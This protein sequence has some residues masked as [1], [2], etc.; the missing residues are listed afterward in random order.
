MKIICTFV[1]LQKSKFRMKLPEKL[2]Q[3]DKIAIISSA[4]KVVMEEIQF[5]IETVTSWG[6]EVVLGKN[7]FAQQ[8]Q[9]AG[10]DEQRA[11]DLQTMLDDKSV[12]A[13]LFARGGYGTVRV[14]DKI[15]FFEFKKNPKWICGFSDITIL[16]SHIHSHF[17]I[18][19]L[20]S[21]M[22][23][24]FSK[25]PTEVLEKIKFVLLNSTS[26]VYETE[27]HLLNKS[28][29][30]KGILVGGN[31]SML[32]SALGS[33]S[34]VDTEGKILFLEDLDE[35]LY[36]IDRMMMSLK[37]AG[38][39]KNLAGLVIGGMNDMKD[40]TI[41]FGKNAEEIILDA[42]KEYDFPV[43]FNFSSG[44]ISNNF[45]LIFGREIELSV[46]KKTML[47]FNNGTA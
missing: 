10:S 39:L 15:N 14:I 4:R 19:T 26:L 33:E 41:P 23:F 3:G 27:K 46:G 36:H 11:E 34:D 38:K 37:R 25:T 9:F 21:P 13:I 8:N 7:L 28:G 6:F 24:N 32:Y 35:Y 40:N 42:V 5:A 18:A 43:C 45:P 44:H 2:V 30:A 20:H 16:H 17:G 12:K 29:N 47:T 22:A 31:L 1:R